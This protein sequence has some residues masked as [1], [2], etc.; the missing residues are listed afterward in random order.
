MTPSDGPAVPL[1]DR[2]RSLAAADHEMVIRRV[3]EDQIVVTEGERADSVFVLIEGSLVVTK[4]IEG[5]D[6]VLAELNAP[7]T[8]VGEMVSLGGGLR[9]ATVKTN[10]PSELYSIPAT[11]FQ[12]LL[13]TDRDFAE[14]LSALAVRRAEEGELAEIIVERLGV[15]DPSRVA[16]ACSAVEW[17][18]LEAGEVLFNEGD[19]SDAVYFVVRGRLRREQQNSD[20]PIG[21]V[22]KGGLIGDL[23][24]LSDTPRLGRVVALRHSVVA[25]MTDDTFL[26]IAESQPGVLVDMA[27]SAVS[28]YVH[29][30][31]R[32]APA[33][34][35]ALVAPS[36]LRERIVDGFGFELSTVGSVESLSADRVDAL[37]E[38]PGISDSAEGEVGN[39]RVSRLL[40]ELELNVDHLI[41]D[42]GDVA[43]PWSQRALD[44]ADHVIVATQDELSPS[45][46]SRLGSLLS[47]CRSGVPR[48][49]LVEHAGA[50]R[51]TG[52]ARL[53]RDLGCGSAL[54]VARD[55]VSDLA[56][57]AR[58]VT[59]RAN[60]LV[61]GGGGARGFA[62]I[63][64][65]RA[66]RELEIPIDI[67]AGTSIG[68]VFGALIADGNTPEDLLVL[69]RENFSALLDYTLPVVSLIKGQKIAKLALENFGDREIS[70]LWTTFLCVSTDL[71]TSRPHVHT[72]GSLVTAIRATSAIPGVMPPVPVEDALL[73]DGGVLN[74]LPIDIARSEAPIGRVLA[75]DVAPPRGPGAHG[76]Y[77]LAVSGWKALR[78]RTGRQR[79]PYPGIS[80]VLMRSMITASM[81]E[82]D[83]QV[84]DGLADFYLNLDIRGVSMLDF[85]DPVS[86]ATRGYEAAKSA[87]EQWLDPPA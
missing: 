33:T 56:R 30:P 41:L 49:L 62:H 5:H 29:A 42:V 77:G 16:A 51:P 14:H 50:S 44:L 20:A 58:V 68:G 25:E 36:P 45:E 10:A 80:A 60:C 78:A 17:R 32:S 70:D 39:V 87:L 22:G 35:V 52:T 83:R 2:L 48:T 40:D 31:A 18:K 43:G 47:D 76:D 71:T 66:I 8:V 79:S 86:V 12:T 19:P 6:A 21:T 23:G 11:M 34:V 75:F 53:I 63:G 9:T 82:R 55:S 13:T 64:A 59:G 57:A 54:H 84:S 26:G 15:T 61:I 65:Y 81:R 37:L 1:L 69:A 74:N 24:V 67:V 73:V 28:A 72:R 3:D 4:T 46:V 85:S 7:G 38:T 27:R